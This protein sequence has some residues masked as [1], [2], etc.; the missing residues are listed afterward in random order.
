MAKRQDDI[1]LEAGT[2]ELEVL[3]FVIGGNSFGINVA[4][5]RELMQYKPVQPLPRSHPFV[6]GIFQP[7]QEVFTVLDL[8]GYLGLGESAEPEKD[9][10]I[11]AGFN[12][13]NIAFHVHS[14]ENIHRI[15]WGAIEKPDPTVY[16]GQDGVITGIAKIKDHIIAIIDF[17][18]IV[19]DISP[20]TGIQLSEIEAMGE[21]PRRDVPIVVAEDS[22]L[23][24]R[25]ITEALQKS[26]YMNLAMCDNGESAWEHIESVKANEN[27]T[28]ADLACVITDIEMP[29]MD[30]HH[31]TKLIKSDPVLKDVPVVIFSSLIDNIMRL[32]GEEVGANA[33]LSKPEIGMLVSVID[34]LVGVE[35]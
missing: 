15:Y 30:G 18:K 31:L 20:E 29:R 32:K 16:G 21:R 4:K 6:E 9:I 13:L 1:L 26:G 33:Q 34:N 27:F 12:Q 2:N 10:L 17:E 25:M 14:V 3:E 8:S 11:I 5:V 7:R 28:L 22:V 19:Y 24:R 23:L 35:S